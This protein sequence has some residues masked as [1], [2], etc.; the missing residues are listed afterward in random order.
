MEEF[1]MNKEPLKLIKVGVQTIV[2]SN[3]AIL[4][5]KR[6]NSFQ[7]GSWGLPGGHLELD[8]TILQAAARELKEE[9]G[10]VSKKLRVFCVTDPTPESNYHM[11]VGVIVEA[12]EGTPSIIEPQKCSELCFFDKL[13]LPH[14]IFV[15][16]RQI[17]ENYTSKN[18]YVETKFNA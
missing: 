2:T 16:S 11:Q 4:L 5:G 9:T 12:F 18:V 15:S 7:K 14:P 8:E 6:K 10:L 1:V 17:I 13:S 3:G